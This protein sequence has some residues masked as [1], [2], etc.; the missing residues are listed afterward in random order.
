MLPAQLWKQRP[1]PRGPRTPTAPWATTPIGVV[2][3]RRPNN[4]GQS[5]LSRA[6]R[7][8]GTVETISLRTRPP[9]RVPT[10]WR[11]QRPGPEPGH[12]LAETPVQHSTRPGQAGQPLLRE[13]D[14]IPRSSRHSPRVLRHP[15]PA[16]SRTTEA[17]YQQNPTPLQPDSLTPGRPSRTAPAINP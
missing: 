11:D 8:G 3:H 7:A 1:G 10:Y 13:P 15:S 9:S 12:S 4:P 6:N 14:A 5:S 2:P 16:A 17:I